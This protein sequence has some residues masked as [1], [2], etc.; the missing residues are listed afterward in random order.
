MLPFL[1][2][3]DRPVIYN[4]K[5]S[6][7]REG[8]NDAATLN[9]LKSDSLRVVFFGF[10]FAVDLA[11]V[12]K[13]FFVIVSEKGFL[14]LISHVPTKSSYFCWPTSGIVSVK[15]RTS[16]L[17]TM[18]VLILIKESSKNGLIGSSFPNMVV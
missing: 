18:S 13:L 5:T 4:P 16:S 8:Q 14:H 6:A 2:H 10:A 17:Y 1:K 12:T 15:A 7:Q 11:G 3:S 9:L